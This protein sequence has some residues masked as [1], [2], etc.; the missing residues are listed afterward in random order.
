MAQVVGFLKNGHEERIQVF[1]L[2]GPD[3]F[4]RQKY[5]WRVP[6]KTFEMLSIAKIDSILLG[7][8]FSNVSTN[9]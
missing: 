6:F 8:V 1:Q 4:G 3:V 9:H 5:S 2:K 7:N